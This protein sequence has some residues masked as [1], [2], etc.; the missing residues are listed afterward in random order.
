MDVLITVYEMAIYGKPITYKP[1]NVT[2]NT[3]HMFS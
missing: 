3:K 2:Y 1:N